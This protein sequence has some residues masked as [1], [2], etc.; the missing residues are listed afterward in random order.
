MKYTYSN[1]L[2]E[3]PSKAEKRQTWLKYKPTFYDIVLGTTCLPSQ[4]AWEK[5]L[6]F[7]EKNVT[8]DSQQKDRLQETGHVFANT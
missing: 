1:Y 5:V 3:Q 4:G 2:T 6:S 8:L 7:K